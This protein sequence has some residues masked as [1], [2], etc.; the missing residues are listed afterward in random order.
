MNEAALLQNYLIVG[1]LLFGIG[2][3][4][5]IVRRNMI[6]MFLCAEMMLQGVSVSAIAFG[7]YH[8]DWGGQMLVIFII[9]VAAAEAGIAL[10]LILMLFH[11]SGTLDMAF[12]QDMREEGQPA[13]IDHG[14][15]EE[16]DEDRVWPTLTPAGVEPEVNQDEQQHR[17]KV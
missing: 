1:G 2:L 11:K 4:G 15:P 9:A 3:L 17:S 5:F 16:R 14:V 8:N 12:W 7:R 6:V 13:F 10:A